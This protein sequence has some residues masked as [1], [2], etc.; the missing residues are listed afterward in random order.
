MPKI[1]DL[2]GLKITNRLQPP[3]ESEQE[4][5]PTFLEDTIEPIPI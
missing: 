3:S 4:E 1:S 2:Y 5:Q